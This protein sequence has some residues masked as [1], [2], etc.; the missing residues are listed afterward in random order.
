MLIQPDSLFFGSFRD[1][2]SQVWSPS[3]NQMSHRSE[4]QV[5]KQKEILRSSSWLS[6]KISMP[7][8]PL[9]KK[10]VQ[11]ENPSLDTFPTRSIDKVPKPEH[12][13]LLITTLTTR[14]KLKPLAFVYSKSINM[15]DVLYC[16]IMG[17]ESTNFKGQLFFLCWIST[18]D[19]FLSLSMFLES[20]V[21]NS[22]LPEI[23]KRLSNWANRFSNWSNQFS[24]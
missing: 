20:P 22:E 11:K 23:K 10:V 6:S 17:I 1:I 15:C 8:S 13:F 4:M 12:N 19:L 18:P 3:L 16:T 21:S 9:R 7:F 2:S 24:D 5:Q 14:F